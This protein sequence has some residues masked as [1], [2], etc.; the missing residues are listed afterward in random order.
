MSPDAAFFQDSKNPDI[1]DAA[2]H[3]LTQE[4]M[5]ES[6]LLAI[7]NFATKEQLQDCLRRIQAKAQ[8]ESP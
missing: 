4:E 6:C 8:E 5:I 1:F 3:W 7:T 2:Y